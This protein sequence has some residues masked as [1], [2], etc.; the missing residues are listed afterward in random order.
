MFQF[1]NYGVVSNKTKGR[2]WLFYNPTIVA[3]S[4]V[5]LHEQ[6]IHCDVWFKASTQTIAVTFVYGLND[7]RARVGLWD[8]L[9]SISATMTQAW[10]VLADF[11]V[12]KRLSERVGPN[13]AAT[14]DML[15]FNACLDHCYLDDMHSIGSEFTWT[16]KQDADTRTWA[17][18]DRVLV[19]P[20]WLTMFP[21]SF[22]VWLSPGI[23]DHS[24]LLVS[25]APASPIQRRFSFLNV[26]Q[27]HPD[28]KSIIDNAW[29]TPSYGSPM[30]QL[31]HKFKNVRHSLQLLHKKDFSNISGKVQTLKKQLDACQTAL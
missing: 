7:P 15:D 12:V 8:E 27:G 18:L 19:N 23:S 13:P 25:V 2:I 9:S 31:F 29:K 20:D 5:I 22:V 4:N 17:R 10:V 30:F 11:N 24:P 14:H 1:P 3:I 6:L 21:S 16:N 26:W 28:Y